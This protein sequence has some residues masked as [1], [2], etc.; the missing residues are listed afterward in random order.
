MSGG[1]DLPKHNKT[2]FNDLRNKINNFYFLRALK[3]IYLS[4]VYAMG[5]SL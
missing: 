3:K 2:K 4:L 1:N 5:L